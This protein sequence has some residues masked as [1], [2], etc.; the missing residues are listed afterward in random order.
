MLELASIHNQKLLQSLEGN[1]GFPKFQRG[2]ARFLI[3]LGIALCLLM[4]I[5]IL[6]HSPFQSYELWEAVGGLIA[7]VLWCLM[8]YWVL[9][10]RYEF[11]TRE[12]RCYS[13]RR[14]W[15]WRLAFE[16]VASISLDRNT[17]KLQAFLILKDHQGKKREIGCDEVL[18]GKLMAFDVPEN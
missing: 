10:R 12:V 9:K 8:G 16:E 14:H 7:T 17:Q 18:W 5:L 1:Y 15:D 3:A 6:T 4:P 13:L 2:A 11:T